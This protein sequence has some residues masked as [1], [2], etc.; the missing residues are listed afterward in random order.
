MKLVTATED[1]RRWVQQWRETAIYLD[2]VRRHEL[3]QLT[4]EDAWRQIECVQSIKDGWR[5]PNAVCGL[6]E[7]QALFS[8]L[9]K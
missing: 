8:K 4:P 1:E 5:D 9:R 3:S 6:I 7:Q 2:E